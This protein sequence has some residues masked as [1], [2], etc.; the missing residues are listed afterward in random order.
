MCLLVLCVEECMFARKLQKAVQIGN[1]KNYY[2]VIM[3]ELRGTRGTRP[4]LV[5]S[6]LTD[7]D[8]SLDDIHMTTCQGHLR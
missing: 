4:N 8:T 5:A 7:N 2:G 6:N 1:L 3:E